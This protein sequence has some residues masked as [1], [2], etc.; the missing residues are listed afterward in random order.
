MS[1]F[2]AGIDSYNGGREGWPEKLDPESLVESYS[3]RKFM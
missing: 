3:A 2:E 1:D